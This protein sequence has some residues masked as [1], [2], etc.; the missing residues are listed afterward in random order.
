MSNI[1]PTFML[2]SNDRHSSLWLR[3]IEHL[4]IRLN[5]LH[6]KIEPN[7]TENETAIIRGQ[8]RFARELIRLGDEPPTLD[9]QI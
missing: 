5:D 4:N 6:G 1:P 9:G 8:I 2:T 3:L 7:Q